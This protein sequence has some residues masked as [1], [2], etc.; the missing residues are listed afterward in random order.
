MMVALIL[1]KPS[2]LFEDKDNAKLK[3]FGS[4]GPLLGIA[5]ILLSIVVFFFFSILDL[6][7]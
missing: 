4:A 3:Q 2:G 7:E 5:S 6:F 1:M